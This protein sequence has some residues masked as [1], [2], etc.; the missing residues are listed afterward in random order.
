[1]G[2]RKA[3]EGI[4][5][6]LIGAL[7]VRGRK[8]TPHVGVAGAIDET[9]VSPG[10]LE[11]PCSTPKKRGAGEGYVFRALENP[12]QFSRSA[13]SIASFFRATLFDI[14]GLQGFTGKKKL[15]AR[16]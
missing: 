6:R 8:A 14:K 1:M 13:K 2:G 11:F 7:D 5:A 4:D 3:V 10:D 16:F 12:R 9:R 15:G